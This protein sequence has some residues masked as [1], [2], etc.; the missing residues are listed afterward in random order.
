MG[1]RPTS[2]RSFSS[3]VTFTDHAEMRRSV[4]LWGSERFAG[5]PTGF[6]VKSQGVVQ[7]ECAP[8]SRVTCLVFVSCCRFQNVAAV[9]INAEMLQLLINLGA[10]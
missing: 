3:E 6:Q 9:P 8:E 2:D 4:L 7:P 10:A 5:G 1:R